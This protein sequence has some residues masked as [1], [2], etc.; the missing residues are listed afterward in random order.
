M[1]HP[2]QSERA[3]RQ[4]CDCCGGASLRLAERFDLPVAIVDRSA[5]VLAASTTATE[6]IGHHPAL[7]RSKTRIGLSNPSRSAE[8]RFALRRVLS[9]QVMQTIRADDGCQ[10]AP[11]A[12]QVS[13]WACEMHSLVTF[14]MIAPTPIDFSP[15]REPF[16]LTRHQSELLQSFTYGTPLS[17]IARDFRLKSQTMR[18]MFSGLYA[19]FEVANQLE[20]LSALKSIALT[21]LDG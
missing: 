21:R 6:I 4:S 5:N 14:Q 17:E 20:L 10:G 8:F 12:L 11:L 1:G 19:K 2:P 3:L 13:E 16:G 9:G 18:C 15:I 7:L